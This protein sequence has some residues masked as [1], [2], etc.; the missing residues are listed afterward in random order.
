[1]TN[2]EICFSGDCATEVLDSI[3]LISLILKNGSFEYYGF[4]KDWNKVEFY[5]LSPPIVDIK[6]ERK[7]TDLAFT[8]YKS[9]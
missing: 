4:K 9:K 3:N 2:Y 6:G 7:I 1:F 5:K 8:L